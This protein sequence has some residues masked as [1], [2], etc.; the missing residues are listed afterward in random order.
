MHDIKIFACNSAEEFTKEICDNL[1]LPVGEKNA[2]KFTNDNNFVKILETVRDHDVYIV[3][4]TLPPV[5]ERIMELLITMD[6]IRRAS[7]KRI[8]VILPYFMYSR[9]D[10]EDQPRV[11]VTAKLFAQ[12]LEASRSWQSTYM[13]S[14]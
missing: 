14:A 11:P 12:L 10:K 2:Y 9:S 4:T 13:W 3:Q 5:N 7:A 8:V 6:A 1:G